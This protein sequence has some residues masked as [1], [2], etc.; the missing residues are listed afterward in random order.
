MVLNECY[1]I[2]DFGSLDHYCY[3]GVASK[4]HSPNCSFSRQQGYLRNISTSGNI[5]KIWSVFFRWIRKRS[6]LSLHRAHATASHAEVFR[7][8]RKV[9]V[10]LS[11][12]LGPSLSSCFYTLD[13]RLKDRYIEKISFVRSLYTEKGRLLLRLGRWVW[14]VSHI[15]WLRPKV[16]RVLEMFYY[17]TAIQI[18]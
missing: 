8:A 1:S 10:P 14:T 3:T 18:L 17:P 2:V 16:P 9:L 6:R 13:V 11:N 7:I 15:Y 12:V 5:V 4:S